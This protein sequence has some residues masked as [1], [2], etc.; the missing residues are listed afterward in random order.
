MSFVKSAL[1]FLAVSLFLSQPAFCSDDVEETLVTGQTRDGF[2]T[3]FLKKQRADLLRQLQIDQMNRALAEAQAAAGRQQAEQ[4]AK[5]KMECGSR[6]ASING[7]LGG[8]KY[9]A[10]QRRTS[11]IKSCP[12]ETEVV[13]SLPGVVT[14]TTNP[15]AACLL[16]IDAQ[17]QTDLAS[18]DARAD[19]MLA[20]LPAYCFKN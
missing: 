6:R 3:D 4:A 5:Q 11:G 13:T 14:V 8:C 12:P 7:S 18:C 1:Y 17:F 19:S 2:E 16:I 15:Q 20:A 10:N 9:S